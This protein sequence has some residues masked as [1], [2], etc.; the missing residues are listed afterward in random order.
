[1]IEYITI[2]LPKDLAKKLREIAKKDE[3]SVSRCVRKA[4]LKYMDEKK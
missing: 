3:I 2:Y 4:I 1:M